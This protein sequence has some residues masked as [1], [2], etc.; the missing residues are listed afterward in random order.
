MN[1]TDSP[2]N[3]MRR[4]MQKDLPDL[5]IRAK[6]STKGQVVIP[7]DIRRALGIE[8]GNSNEVIFR[9]EK[10]VLYLEMAEPEI[11]LSPDLLAGFL[12]QPEDEGDFHLDVGAARDERTTVI[13]D[14]PIRPFSEE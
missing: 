12:D 5:E 14:K 3:E 10:G 6:V 13:L 11:M 2:S 9:M 1:S 4:D 7:I 8:D